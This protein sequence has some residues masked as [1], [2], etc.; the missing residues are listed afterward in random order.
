MHNYIQNLK[1]YIESK[2]P[3]HHCTSEVITSEEVLDEVVLKLPEVEQLGYVLESD[4]EPCSV[5][6]IR[7]P[8]KLTLYYYLPSRFVKQM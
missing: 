4:K 2:H 5:S 3:D 6:C 8:I 1:E 7:Q